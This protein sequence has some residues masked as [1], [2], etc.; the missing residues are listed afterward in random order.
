MALA[1]IGNTYNTQFT[2]TSFISTYM[3]A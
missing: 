1:N 3:H 2:A